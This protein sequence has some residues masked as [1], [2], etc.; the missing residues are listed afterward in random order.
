M[1]L[2]SPKTVGDSHRPG[3]YTPAQQLF[4][5]R[6][7]RTINPPTIAQR[8]AV[9]RKDIG[10]K[11]T[12]GIVDQFRPL[13]DLSPVAYLLARLSKGSAGALE[14]FLN[15]GKLLIRGGAYDADR[16]G[17]FI[18]KVAAPLRGEIEDFFWWVASHRAEQLTPEDREHLFSKTDIAT[19]K[20][21][22]DGNLSFDYTLANGQT[23]RS[24]R[25]AY[26]DTLIKY[27]GF[28]K[29]AMDMAEQS[30]LVNAA[31]RAQWEKMMYVP[32]YR[33]A[34]D[35]GGFI[36]GNVS[37]KLVGQSPFKRL[38]G[39]GEKLNSDLMQ[40]VIQNW[41]H[42]IDAGIKNRAGKESLEAAAQAGI[43]TDGSKYTLDQL[44]TAAGQKGGLVWFMDEGEKHYYLVDKEH[45]MV[46]TAI[47]SL[48]YAGMNNPMMKAMGAFK[49]YLTIGV[50]ASPVFK[51][52]NLI[53]DSLQAVA[54]SDLSYNVYGNI[55]AGI[56]ASEHSTQTYVSA[57]ASGGLIR[58]GTMLEGNA[59]ARVRQ[60]VK[61]GNKDS[62]ILN[63]D[64]KLRAV[65]DKFDWALSK[66]N[67]L[68]N[69]SEEIT[70]AALYKQLMDPSR[71]GGPLSHAEAS[72]MARDLMD[73]SLQ[74][75][76][77][78]VR[79]LTQVVPFMNARLQG[80]YKLGRAA[81]EDPKPFAIV[82]GAAAVASITLMAIYHDDDDWKKREDWDRNT[83]WWFK[84]G[85]VALRIPKPFE[86][87]AMA[88]LAERGVEYFTDPEMTGKRFTKQVLTLLGDN[89]SMNPIP[90]AV[91]PLIDVYSNKDAFTGRPIE[92]M[93]M[94]KLQP[95]YRFTART[96]MLAR[97]ASTTG[98]AVTSMVNVNFLSPVQIDHLIRG[99]FSWLGTFVVDGS[100]I[101]ARP[102][103]N[104]PTQPTRDLWKTATGGMLAE[105]PA[106]QSRY[107][108]QMYEQA[109]I[110]EQAYGTWRN[111][112]KTG[113]TDEAREF[114]ADNR[115]QL[116]KYRAV[117]HVKREEAKIN[118]A[119]RIIERSSKS[120]DEKKA[121]IAVRNQQKDRIARLV[122]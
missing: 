29:N 7:G 59:S 92:S 23:T 65:Y 117:E 1:P 120:A 69:R 76:Y 84:L 107:V 85:G 2:H 27:D 20:T 32:F 43:A 40:N 54:T 77:A 9:L 35:D 37:A 86:I 52:R 26:A 82:L 53:R 44:Q 31:G 68:G 28:N 89:L 45:Q 67:E 38:K 110:L 95:D 47:T 64:S 81:Q 116:Q 94:E 33:A 16:S 91:K 73:F 115:D 22:A 102:L 50:T 118:E 71:K 100:D 99:Y 39:G 108:S 57:L 96:T 97:A 41:Y 112:I 103:T 3:G 34:P 11:L 49:H 66:Y 5:E 4:H 17:G 61:L 98:Q 106:D 46:L 60:L 12:Q 88:T 56:A 74:G 10:M 90:Q 62:T 15:H 104:E 63:S 75:S 24:R 79:F 21:L 30:G 48:Q 114:Q 25:Q 119:I 36:G 6:V 70:R 83:N 101:L 111:L 19:G 78:T 58:F 105:L 14:A 72:L 113:K 80:M 55:K 18:Q 8:I 42:L 87:G 93:G 109:T 13:K 121:L 122:N 51:V